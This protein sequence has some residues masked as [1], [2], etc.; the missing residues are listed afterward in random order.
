MSCILSKV[1]TVVELRST[2]GVRSRPSAHSSPLKSAPTRD[3]TPSYLPSRRCALHSVPPPSS[4]D[5]VIGAAGSAGGTPWW[6]HT[7]SLN[8]TVSACA[9][10]SLAF[11]LV[12]A[13]HCNP[14]ASK[15]IT[16]KPFTLLFGGAVSVTTPH[17]FRQAH[18]TRGTFVCAFGICNICDASWC[19]IMLVMVQVRCPFTSITP[20]GVTNVANSKNTH[21]GPKCPFRSSR[22]T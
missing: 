14:F 19:I 7:A 6:F 22:R 16:S 1:H 2:D 8:N 15:K 13:D 20:T 10:E 17:L 4:Q 5:A 11:A 12:C 9:P 18:L 21:N 3:R